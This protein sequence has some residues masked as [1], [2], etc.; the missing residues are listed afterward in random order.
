MRILCVED[1]VDS[2]EIIRYLLTLAGYEVVTASSTR[3]GLEFALHESFALIMLDNWYAQGS[4][5][6]LCKKIRAFDSHT[7][8]IFFSG[9]AFETDRQEGIA[10][11]AQAYLTKPTGI[12]ILVKTIEEL[13]H[14]ISTQVA[15]K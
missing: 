13:T 2:R 14:G 5:V 12:K 4:G 3:D 11:G 6:E 8:I 10:A 1:N 15:I 9:A 7:P